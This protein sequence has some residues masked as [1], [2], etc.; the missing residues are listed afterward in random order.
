MS[1][2]STISLP[3]I[4]TCSDKVENVNFIEIDYSSM[5]FINI[6]NIS[7]NT[8]SDQFGVND[9]GNVNAFITDLTNKTAKINFSTNFVGTV[10]YTV[11]GFI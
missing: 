6:P 8:I 5:G 2:S 9:T 10:N 11:V 4:Y 7:V 3:K 1:Y